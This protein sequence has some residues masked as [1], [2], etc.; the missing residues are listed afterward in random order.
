MYEAHLVTIE[1]SLLCGHKPRLYGTYTLPLGGRAH[2]FVLT[3]MMMKP[4]S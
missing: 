2:L 1:L 3:T 4:L